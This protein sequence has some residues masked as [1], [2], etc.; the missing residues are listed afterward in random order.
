MS[1]VLF[2][3]NDYLNQWFAFSPFKLGQPFEGL[4]SDLMQACSSLSHGSTFADLFS[5]HGCFLIWK[6]CVGR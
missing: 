1:L 2:I 4:F 6:T 5:V 3:R